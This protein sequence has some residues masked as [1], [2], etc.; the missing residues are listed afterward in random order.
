MVQTEAKAA[1]TA[2]LEAVLIQREGNDEKLDDETKK[3]FKTIADFGE[4]SF[5]QEESSTKRKIEEEPIVEE[6]CS[7]N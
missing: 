4:I 3:L 5:E 2:K 1:Q 6:V 7:N